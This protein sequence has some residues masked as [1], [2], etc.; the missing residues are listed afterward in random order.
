MAI[1]VTG[2]AGYIG[3]V[4][5]EKLI[6]RGE[7]VVV[8]DNLSRGHRSAVQNEATFYQFDVGDQ[9]S[10]SEILE[11]HEITA[12][13]HFA[14]FAYV[15]ESVSEPEL[16][17]RNNVVQSLNLFD[18]LIAHG[19]RDVIFSSTC[20]TY[21][22]PITIPIDETH[23][24]N[25]V[26]PYGMTKLVNERSLKKRSERKELKYV[27]LRYF[28]AAG[29]SFLHGE[30]HRPETHLIPLILS[31]AEDGPNSPVYIFGDD[32]PTPDGTAVRDYIHVEDLAHAHL[33]A[34]DY[35]KRGGESN[36][37]NLGTGDGSSV[38][39][40]ID[41]AMRVT[42]RTVLCE[43]QGRRPGDPS[44]LVADASRAASILDWKPGKSDLDSILESAWS[45]KK[46]NPQGYR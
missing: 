20:A 22:E 13:F 27:S 28:N 35:L 24:Q 30:D 41:S 1:L 40:I 14:A 19:V 25:P 15:G 2:G 21:G 29:A 8:I 46:R 6:E 45:W 4:T 12:C 38:R 43:I 44:H 5:V 18:T 32:Y 31:A 34:L 37:F 3:S 42:G 33:L 23:P 7:D 16:Y 36:V 39:Q 17:Y 11:S 26:N 10:L 9:P